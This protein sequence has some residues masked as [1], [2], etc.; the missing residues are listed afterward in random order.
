M[1]LRTAGSLETLQDVK[2]V[3]GDRLSQPVGNGIDHSWFAVK[4]EPAGYQ[5]IYSRSVADST[6]RVHADDQAAIGGGASVGVG[7]GWSGSCGSAQS[8][9][10]DSGLQAVEVEV[11]DGSR[12]Q[13]QRLAENQAANDGDAE[14]AAH[15]GSG[16]R[17]RGQRQGAEQRGSGGHHDR[18]EAQ[19]ARL[20][21]RLQAR[22]AALA[23]GLHGEVDHQDR[24]FLDQVRSTE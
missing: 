9:A 14:R 13:G 20:I 24:V 21:N 5:S 6:I 18:A 1:S 17:A 19:Q 23:L 4:C 2:P 11:D 10:L 12:E 16:A 15:F 3:R 7:G 8:A 22:L